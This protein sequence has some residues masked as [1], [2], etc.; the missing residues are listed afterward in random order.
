MD[1]ENF[2]STSTGDKF[3]LKNNILES[4]AGE[5][6]QILNKINSVL[7]QKSFLII[8]RFPDGEFHAHNELDD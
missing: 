5:K 4:K 6:I 1:F 7:M 2:I 3:I 8:Q